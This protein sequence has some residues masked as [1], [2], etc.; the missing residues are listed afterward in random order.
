MNIEKLSFN[1]KDLL[2][3]RLRSVDTPISEYTFANIYLFRNPHNYE[4]V[5]DKELFIKGK[6]Y[7]GFIYLMPTTDIRKINYDYLKNLMKD[8]DFLFP[9]PEEWLGIFNTDEFEFSYKEEDMD[10]IYTVEKISTFKGRK[11]H[12]KRNLLKQFMRLYENEAYPLTEERMEDAVN[13]LNQWKE[14][15][16]VP[17]QETDYDPC[18]EALKLYDNLI[19]CGGIYYVDKEPGGFIIGEELD[20]ET[21]VLHFAKGKRKFKGL[22][23][24]MY[25]TF[26]KILPKK[27]KYLNFEQDL[28]HLALKIA[29]SSYVP[30]FMLKKYRI[31][32]K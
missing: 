4:V 15:I 23:Q 12:K 32:L 24:Y 21:F 29:K 6:T 19:L 1:H 27:Y 3:E 7:D 11:L 20:E 9:M 14:D 25:N 17:D 31:R 13:I 22:Y 8:A 28:G 30:D 16:G 18:L 2:Y 26:A 10:Y 5:F